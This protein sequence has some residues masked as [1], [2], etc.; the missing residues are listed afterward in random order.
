ML[1][2]NVSGIYKIRNTKT[3]EF[4]IGSSVKLNK[5]KNQHFLA[6][7]NNT[8]CNSHLQKVYNKYTENNLN[9]EILFTCPKEHLIELEQLC[10]DELNPYYNI[11][12]VAGGSPLGLKRSDITRS[13]ISIAHKGKKLTETHKLKLVKGKE[14]YKGKI[15]Q[16]SVDNKLIKIWD[17]LT[18]DIATELNLKKQ[19][20]LEVLCNRRNSLHGFKFKYEKEVLND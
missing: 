1:I 9:F 7:R 12:K 19:S 8:H 2:N 20:I 17:C 15:Y 13:K 11:Q 6:L 3:D 18:K 16:Y 4:Y 10:I 5:R 14:N